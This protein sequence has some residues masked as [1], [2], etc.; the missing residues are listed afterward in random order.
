MGFKLDLSKM[1]HMKSDKNS[2]TFQHPGGHLITI[3]HNTLAPENK[4]VLA[5]VIKKNKKP[6]YDEGGKVAAPAQ[7]STER[8]QPIKKNEL[9]NVGG[10][11]GAIDNAKKELGFSDGGDVPP[12]VVMA[13]QSDPG[14]PPPKPESQK[15][16]MKKVSEGAEKSGGFPSL[17][18]LVDRVKHGMAEGGRAKMAGGGY[19]ENN[20]SGSTAA[21]A[22]D[23]GL[24]CLNPN[25]KSQGRP[26][27]N[28]RCY[29]NMAEGG[30]ISKLR[31][32]AHGKPHMEDC[33]YNKMAEGGNVM[34]TMYAEGT[35]E[36]IPGGGVAPQPAPVPDYAQPQPQ[37]VSQLSTAPGT[38]P[39]FNSVTGQMMSQQPEATQP[40]QPQATEAQPE[41][42]KAHDSL[43]L[44]QPGQSKEQHAMDIY[45][46]MNNEA[47]AIAQDYGNGH[48]NPKTYNDLMY[49]NKDGSEKSTVGKLG[50]IFGLLL[51]G[52][53]SGL[54]HQQNMALEMMNKTIDRDIDAQKTTK[55]DQLNFLN[56]AK[57]YFRTKSD[58][59]LQG[60]HGKLL[61]AQTEQ[62]KINNDILAQTLAKNSMMLGFVQQLTGMSANMPP[63]P[64]KAQATA[65]AG[66]VGN[67]VH[68]KILQNNARAAQA[69][70]STPGSEQDYNDTTQ[71]FRGAG[72]LGLEGADNQVGYR[73]SHQIPGV[74]TTTVP[75]D[76]ATKDRVLKIN[77]FQNLLHEAKNLAEAQKLGPLSPAQKVRANAIESDLVSSYNDVKGLNRFTSNEEALYKDVV[78]HLSSNMS[79]LTGARKASLDR[80]IDSVQQKKDL[81][82]KQL[83]VRPFSDAQQ[84]PQE[85]KEGQTGKYKGKP[86][87]FRN[88]KWTP[89]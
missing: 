32:C 61:A 3:A 26:H 71:K 20:A 31:Y 23:A 1:K 27:P 66:A 38:D 33:E 48:I 80:L 35:P 87:V 46:Q 45:Q 53:G 76:G 6:S 73:E 81:E 60:Q 39:N 9:D 68:Q 89:Q 2:T 69:A 49:H 18:E 21:G 36:S 84:K 57:D 24:P 8:P 40:E 47:A 59:A 58:I 78:P 86:V 77:N 64:Q 17:H 54:A 62:A 22:Y 56:H 51:S 15:D 44:P 70:S 67:A 28:C 74:G 7:T 75:A 88:G 65:A 34:P 42:E 72:M 14:T 52:A 19:T 55:Q 79:A 41:P 10:W 37:Q 82:Y 63:G 43:A 16:K 29:A 25:C 5:E 50:S 85:F 4:A 13:G 12:P 30:E 83:G 11:Q